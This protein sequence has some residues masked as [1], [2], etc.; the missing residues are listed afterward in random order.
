MASARDLDQGSPDGSPQPVARVHVDQ[1]AWTDWQRNGNTLE[2]LVKYCL[3]C[4]FK[5]YYDIKVTTA[6]RTA[7]S[8]SSRSSE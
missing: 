3:Q 7:P 5:L 8:T 2:I 4:Y 6:L 1:K